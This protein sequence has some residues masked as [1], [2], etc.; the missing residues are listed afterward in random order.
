[1]T[2]LL[3]GLTVAACSLSLA[4]CLMARMRRRALEALVRAWEE[5]ADDAANN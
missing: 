4:A 2:M 1:M 5:G 3:F